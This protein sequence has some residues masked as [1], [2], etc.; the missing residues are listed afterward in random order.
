MMILLSS[1]IEDGNS[2]KI[3]QEKIK[4]IVESYGFD[5]ELIDSKRSSGLRVK[6]L[7]EFETVLKA[8]KNQEINSAILNRIFDEN[9]VNALGFVNTDFFESRSEA[10]AN[11]ENKKILCIHNWRNVY[12]RIGIGTAATYIDISFQTGTGSGLIENFNSTLGG[13][14]FMTA[15]GKNSFL[16]SQ[17]ASPSNGDRYSGIYTYSIKYVI[18]VEGIGDVWTSETKH[19]RI[20]VEACTGV[21]SYNLI[22]Q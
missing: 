20:Q 9:G 17:V 2:E 1:C 13:L 21:V 4:G 16:N 22:E 15:L 19:V 18:F 3:H 8:L 14:T 10:V 12:G 6:D 11:P 5:L 7:Y